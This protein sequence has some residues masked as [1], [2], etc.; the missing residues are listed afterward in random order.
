[1]S[2]SNHG[3]VSLNVYRCALTGSLQL[4]V[5][6]ERPDESS[7]G[8]RLFGEKFVGR[9]ERLRRHVLDERDVKEL[10][11]YLTM[12]ARNLRVKKTRESQPDTKSP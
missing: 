1:M 9:S 10:R 8:Y 4:S 2:K 5:D 7:H 3:T 11:S 6:F 12:A